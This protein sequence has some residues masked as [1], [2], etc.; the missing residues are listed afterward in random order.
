MTRGQRLVMVIRPARSDEYEAVLDLVARA[1]KP[2]DAAVGIAAATIHS[3]PRFRPEHLRVAERGGRLVG[4]VNLIDRMVRIG[5]AEARC[6]IVAPLAT[7]PEHQG[8]GV[9]SALM[10]DALEWARN[11][12]FLLSMLWGHPWLY[13]RYGYAPGIKSYRVQLPATTAPF[14]ESAYTLRP[15]APDDSPALAQVYH[16]A[17]ATTSLAERRGDQPWEWRS[18]DPAVFTEVAVDPANAIRGYMRVASRDDHLSAG[19]LM[20]LDRGA[21]RAFIDRLIHLARERNIQQIVIVAPPDQLVSRVA[22]GQ[23]AQICVGSG[24]GAGMV[25]VLDFPALLRAI[26]PELRRRVSRS[27]WI[28]RQDDVRIETPVGRATVHVSHG[29]IEIDDR[30]VTHAITLPFHALGPLVTGYQGIED[31]RA[32]TGVYI[33]GRDTLRLIDVLFPAGHPHWSFAAYYGA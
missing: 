4:M 13:P 32:A 2:G 15:Y 29:D 1:F 33:D 11:H 20:A 14:G 22:W 31:I 28:C 19:E 25:R 7:A 5:S 10:R 6:A 30:R 3:D 23:G 17:T 8:S 18:P 26:E 27:E 12:G 9:G 24:G 21:A 16:A